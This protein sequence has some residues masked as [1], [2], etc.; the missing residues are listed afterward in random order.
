M[1]SDLTNRELQV[2]DLLANGNSNK[3]IAATLN[4]TSGRLNFS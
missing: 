2:V 4:I 1:N 3:Q